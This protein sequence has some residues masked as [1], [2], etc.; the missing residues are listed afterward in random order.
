M[1]SPALEWIVG[2]T[3]WIGA[4]C[5]AWFAGPA[6][7]LGLLACSL[8][9]VGC[10]LA[11]SREWRKLLACERVVRCVNPY[12]DLCSHLALKGLPELMAWRRDSDAWSLR[13]LGS[14]EAPKSWPKLMA[15]ERDSDALS[16]RETCV[17]CVLTSLTG[18]AQA[19]GVG[20]WCRCVVP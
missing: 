12:R 9:L 20:T 4:A 18:V 1:F 11:W 16:L 2:T 7:L 19:H 3:A 17:T 13:D 5:L 6:C 8:D 15:W 10:L 14:P